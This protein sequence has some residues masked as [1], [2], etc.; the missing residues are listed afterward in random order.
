MRTVFWCWQSAA[1]VLDTNP[2]PPAST[3]HNFAQLLIQVQLPFTLPYIRN[4]FF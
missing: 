3:R 2:P 1:I 4:G